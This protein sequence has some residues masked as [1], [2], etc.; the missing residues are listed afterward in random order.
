MKGGPVPKKGKTE[1]QRD[2]EML[3]YGEDEE[4]EDQGAV[5]ASPRKLRSSPTLAGVGQSR[6][7]VTLAGMAGAAQGLLEGS[8]TPTVAISL[9]FFS[10]PSR[11]A[12]D[13]R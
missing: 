13:N 5:T 4:K 6:T 10:A 8:M 3:L 1:K 2:I 11:F 9:T 7:A 12:S